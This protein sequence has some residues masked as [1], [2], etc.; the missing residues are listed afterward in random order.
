M[1]LDP[2]VF[3]SSPA[4]PFDLVL[5]LQQFVLAVAQAAAQL[6][7]KQRDGVAHTPASTAPLSLLGHALTA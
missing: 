6:D 3:A 5:L 7:A 4:Q 1:R 2:V